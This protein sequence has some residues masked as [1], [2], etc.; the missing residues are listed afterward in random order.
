MAGDSQG[1]MRLRI[2]LLTLISALGVFG[3]ALPSAADDVRDIKTQATNR[4]VFA[5]FMVRTEQWKSDNRFES[6]DLLF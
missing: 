5:H 2:L 6:T 3:S 4:L 1:T